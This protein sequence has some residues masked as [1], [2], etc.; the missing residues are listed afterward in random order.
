[1]LLTGLTD[2][3]PLWDL[4]QVNCLALVSL[5]CV[6]AGQFLGG[7]VLFLLGFVKGSSSLQVVFWGCF[8]SRA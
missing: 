1:M 5:G 3:S 7:L 8:C 2:V 6:V 4:S